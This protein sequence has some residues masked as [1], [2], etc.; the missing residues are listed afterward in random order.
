MST[1]RTTITP[2]PCHLQNS[3]K[4][5]KIWVILGLLVL[6]GCAAITDPVMHATH[7]VQNSFASLGDLFYDPETEIV[8]EENFSPGTSLERDTLGRQRND[9]LAVRTS[10]QRTQQ[11]SVGESFWQRQEE[12]FPQPEE[13]LPGIEPEKTQ[14]DIADI[15]LNSVKMSEELNIWLAGRP[16]K[17][18]VGDYYIF[19]NPDTIWTVN[20][21][22]DGLVHWRSDTGAVQS[23]YANPILP[24][25]YW[26]SQLRGEGRRTIT[27]RRGHLFPMEVGNTIE[28]TANVNTDREPRNWQ[29]SWQCEVTDKQNKVKTKLGTLDLFTVLC[30]WE[31]QRSL[32]FH[33]AP[34]VGHYI[35]MEVANETGIRIRELTAY[36]NS[37]IARLEVELDLFPHDAKQFA[38]N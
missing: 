28:F 31:D 9:L 14:E 5:K 7:R 24:A 18:S 21:I 13:E 8:P 17:Y 34:R 35:K 1:I 23:T 36:G 2:Q 4:N 11:Q 33:Y 25:V 29:L 26:K 22:S 38:V 37:A 27:H 6:G 30:G 20:D 10:K 3:Q 12:F 32:M 16:P 19:S 15:Y